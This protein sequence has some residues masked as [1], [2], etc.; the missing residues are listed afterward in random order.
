[1]AKVRAK[2]VPLSERNWIITDAELAGY[3]CMSVETLTKKYTGTQVPE[4]RRLK[5]KYLPDL[6]QKYYSKK[7]VDE[8][9]ETGKIKH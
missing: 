7:M 3:L 1:M 4:E 9:I 6:N 5:P 8:W 2:V